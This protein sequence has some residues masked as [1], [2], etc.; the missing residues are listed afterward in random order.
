MKELYYGRIPLG[1]PIQKRPPDKYASHPYP[2]LVEKQD[3]V[4]VDIAVLDSVFEEVVKERFF[5]D[6]SDQFTASLVPTDSLFRSVIRTRKVDDTKDGVNLD[7]LTHYT[8]PLDSLRKSVLI[9][10]KQDFKEAFSNEVKPMES[11]FK[12]VVVSHKVSGLE[13]VITQ[14]LSPLDIIKQE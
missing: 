5:G 7:T 3:C 14:T 10:N 6:E 11:T 9:S 8:K 12:R 2:V 1:V 4:Y 13:D